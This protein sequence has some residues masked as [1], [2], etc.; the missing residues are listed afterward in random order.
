MTIT[1]K[2][3]AQE[4][5]SA[6]KT[7]NSVIFPV[8]YHVSFPAN[9]TPSLLPRNMCTGQA[10]HL[11]T[12]HAAAAVASTARCNKHSIFKSSSDYLQDRVYQDA[13][14]CGPVSQ[15]GTHTDA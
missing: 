5:L 7:L 1:Y 15:L 8:K 4:Y 6:V 9:L 14:A 3:I 2:P 12:A 10:V 11:H 13:L